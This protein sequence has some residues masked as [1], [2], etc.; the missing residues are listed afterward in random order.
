MFESFQIIYHSIPTKRISFT[1]HLLSQK[2]LNNIII[3][4]VKT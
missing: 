2:L 4:M 1:E 3:L